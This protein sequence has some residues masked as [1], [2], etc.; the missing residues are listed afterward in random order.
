MG[1]ISS[2]FSEW[3]FREWLI[4][5]HPRVK[6]LKKARQCTELKG[7]APLKAYWAKDGRRQTDE[8][9]LA[10]WRCKTPAHWKFTAL[11]RDWLSSNGVMCM[12]HLYYRAVFG[13][14]DE[15]AATEKLMVRTGYATPE[16]TITQRGK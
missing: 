2:P 14:M 4:Q 16:Q 10:K 11:K 15:T 1:M 13:S 6:F 7:G 8:A 9:I 12:H 5:C 3:L